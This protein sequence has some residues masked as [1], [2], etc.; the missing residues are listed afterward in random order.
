MSVTND[1]TRFILDDLFS[2]GIW[3]WREDTVGIPLQGGGFRPAGKKGK[4]DVMGYC[5]SGR[6]LCIEVKTGKDR[7]RPEQVGFQANCQRFNV[8]FLVVHDK[9]DY[10]NQLLELIR[11]YPLDFSVSQCYN[12]PVKH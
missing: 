2:R 3:A 4:P 12:T 1:L 7:L 9:D 11:S 6:G 10:S 5:P 8:F